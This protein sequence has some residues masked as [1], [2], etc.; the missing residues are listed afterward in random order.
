MIVKS[1]Q[2]ASG[3]IIVAIIVEQIKFQPF[4]EIVLQP[5]PTGLQLKNVPQIPVNPV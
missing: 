2:F 4:T 1:E 5:P 3:I